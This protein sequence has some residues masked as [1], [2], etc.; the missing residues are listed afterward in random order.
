MSFNIDENKKKALN[1]AMKEIDKMY[2]VGT[3]MM[4]GDGTKH[5]VQHIP[6]G[7]LSLD[8]ALGIGGYPKGRIVELFGPESSGKTTVALHAIASCQNEGGVAAFIDAEHALDPVYAQKIGV[9]TEHMIISQPDCGEQAIDVAEKL[10][11]SGA[12]DI[13]VID[14]VA[15]LIPRSE[16]EGD[17]DTASVGV[18]ARLMSKAMRKLAGAVNNSKCILIFINQIREKVGV[19]YGC[20]HG[21]TLVN[22][23]DGRSIPIRDVVKKQIKGNVWSYNESLKQFESKTIIDWHD[24]GK[25]NTNTDYIHFETVGIEHSGGRFGFTV[26]PN[27]KVMTKE[28]WKE[29]KDIRLTDKI[30]SKYH[31][32]INGSVAD[33]IWGTSIGDTTIRVR[34]TNTACI[35]FQDA[36]NPDYVQWKLNKL[37]PFLNFKS[38]GNRYDSDYCFELKLIKEE[39]EQRNPLSMLTN[40]YSDMGLALWFMDDAHLDLNGRERVTLSVKRFKNN[41]KILNSIAD[42]LER[43]GVPCSSI[44]Y[45]SGS[46]VCTKNNLYNLMD[47]IHTYVPECMQYKLL[48]VYRGKYNDFTLFNSPCVKEYFVPI[49]MIRYASDRQMRQK[50]KYD[51]TIEDN[52]NY[53]VGGT[54]NGIIVHN[55][56]ETTTGGRAL[57]FFASVRID[58]RPVGGDKGKVKD[59][60]EVIG[61]TVHAK[62]VKN[63]VAP[64]FKEA[65]FD[66]IYGK[67]I[68]CDAQI[69]SFAVDMGI[70]QKSGSWFTYGEDRFHGM[71]EVRDKFENNPNF[72]SEIIELVN[73]SDFGN[74]DLDMNDLDDIDLDEV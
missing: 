5:A 7:C 50:T 65:Y 26:T 62:I 12:I 58:I 16:L 29:A 66:I 24:N 9:D 59:G 68:S 43:V 34:K 64:P 44:V 73:N 55:S 13:I 15:A 49:T 2:G 51:I 71:S 45:S 14:S 22:F 6:T 60:S 32:V 27:H 20:L 53:L 3:V 42:A 56:P 28:G 19:M 69:L 31:S 36:Q 52:H 37:T 54:T 39:L 18:Q 74:D 67:G 40:H 33:F 4:M 47:K 38:N 30:L 17:M 8:K 1:A 35:S 23:V 61:N 21:D 63:K 41:E 25:I 57:K 72:R 46:F 48:P 70:I 10:I 11:K